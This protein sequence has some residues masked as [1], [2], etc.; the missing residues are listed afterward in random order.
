MRASLTRAVLVIACSLPACS[1]GPAAVDGLSDR[2]PIGEPRGDTYDPTRPIVDLRADVNRN[3]TVDLTDPT[4]DLNEDTWDAK[5]GAIFLAN[6][7]DDQSRCPKSGTDVSLAA[8]NDAADEVT[9]GPDDELDLAPL[10]TVPWPGAPA[11]AVG[12]IAVSEKAKPHVRL[13]KK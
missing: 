1:S 4:E 2:L 7:D 8:C 6:I 13:F 3:G 9:N 10:R 11:D 5:H 12:S